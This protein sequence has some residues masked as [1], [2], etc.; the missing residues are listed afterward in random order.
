MPLL[1]P[2][3]LLFGTATAAGEKILG[4]RRRGRDFFRRLRWLLC[5]A[6]MERDF[7]GVID[8]A[9]KG[10]GEVVVEDSRTEP[11]GQC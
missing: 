1:L 2:P 6:S 4:T 11:A 3:L 7:L 9:G 10:G 5:F 8:R